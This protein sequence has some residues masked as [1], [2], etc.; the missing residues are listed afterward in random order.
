M[1]KSPAVVS[2]QELETTLWPD[3]M[4][5]TNNL[6]VQLY[7]LRRQLDKPFSTPLIHTVPGHGVR[8]GVV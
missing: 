2:R 7:Q 1:R 3:D 8:I 6:R 4:P 5:D